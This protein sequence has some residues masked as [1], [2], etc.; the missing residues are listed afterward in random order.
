M[1]TAQPTDFNLNT[2][3]GKFIKKEIKLV[4]EQQQKLEHSVTDKEYFSTLTVVPAVEPQAICR[5]LGGLYF[6]YIASIITKSDMNLRNTVHWILA[7][8]QENVAVHM[9]FLPKK[10]DMGKLP[11]ILPIDMLTPEEK[12]QAGL[13]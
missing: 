4:I 5:H 11:T 12:A 1:W 3:D 8:G 7:W 2:K 6:E 10:S 13:R 9:T